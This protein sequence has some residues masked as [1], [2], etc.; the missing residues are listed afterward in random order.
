[1]LYLK[2]SNQAGCKNFCK[3]MKI[4]KEVRKKAFETWLLLA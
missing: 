3:Y 4:E 1:M 2:K